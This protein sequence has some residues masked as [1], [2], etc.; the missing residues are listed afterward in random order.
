MHR[1]DLAVTGGAERRPGNVPLPPRDIAGMSSGV[2][3]LDPSQS[4]TRLTVERCGSAS[5]MRI[6]KT[7]SYL[8]VGGRL[9]GLPRFGVEASIQGACRLDSNA[10]GSTRSTRAEPRRLQRRGQIAEQPHSSAYL[11]FSTNLDGDGA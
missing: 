11:D 6:R 10:V 8:T 7:V 3:G 2:P 9:D 5:D 1:A 4:D